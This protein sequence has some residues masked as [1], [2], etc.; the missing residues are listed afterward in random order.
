MEESEEEPKVAPELVPEV[1]QEETPAEG[2]MITVRTV[3]APPTHHVVHE[4]H[5]RQCPVLPP[6]RALPPTR[7]WRWSWS[8]PPLTRRTTSPWVKP[9]ARLTRPCHKRGASC[10]MKVRTLLMSVGASSYG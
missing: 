10:T 3:V 1:V 9:L 7:E 5:L 8:I 6:P 2:A 4:H